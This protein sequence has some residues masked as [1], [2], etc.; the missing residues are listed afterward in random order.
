MEKQPINKRREKIVNGPALWN[1]DYVA[2]E[3]NLESLGYFSARY[4]RPPLDNTQ[5]SKV[6]ALSDNRRVEI[7]PS[8]KYGF[9]NAE[10]LDFYRAFLKICD[11]RAEWLKDEEGKYR[12]QLPSPIGFSSRE[13]IA[14]AGRHKNDRN[15][16]A[17]RNWMKRL[18][19][20]AIHGEL[21]N[22]RTKSF[23]AHIGLEPLFKKF[24]S[25]GEHLPDGQFATQNYVWLSD[26]FV[27]NYYL[28]YTRRLDLNLHNR[29]HHAISKTLFPLLDNGWFASNGAPYTKSYQD[30]CVILDI[31]EHKQL[32]RVRH[33]LDASHEELLREQFIAKYDYPLLATGEWTGNVRWWPGSKWLFDQ[34]QKQWQRGVVT[35]ENLTT[36]PPFLA[37][38]D[39]PRDPDLQPLL[40]FSPKRNIA[41]TTPFENWTQNFYGQLGQKRP[42]RQQIRA[43]AEIIQNLVEQ[44]GYSWEDLDWTLAWINRHLSSRLNGRV[45]SIGIVPHII[46]EALQEKD[47]HKRKQE[48]VR[49]QQQEVQQEQERAAQN[50]QLLKTL[51]QLPETEKERLRKKA[52]TNLLAQGYHRQFIGDA[53]I[54]IEM[55]R[56][57]E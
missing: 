32:S 20:T 9:P 25:V 1:T 7:V 47:L 17:V 49:T 23:D 27:S 22:A 51:A 30:L 26:W 55:A 2:A 4:Y 41:P 10:D 11:E 48:R 57:L 21:Y 42:S 39:A 8:A 3:Q 12:P 33:Q 18:N 43:G 28:F 36:P 34:E 45:Q 5:L 15:T 19:A 54:K 52:V 53:L 44:Q 38:S 37:N 56:L 13:L 40:P 14:K 6:V 29:L 16:I 24:V 35:D 50:K 31:K 46:G